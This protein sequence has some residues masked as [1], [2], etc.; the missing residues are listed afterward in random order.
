VYT[1]GALMRGDETWVYYG[2]GDTVIG[3]ATAKTS[4][5]IE[6]CLDN[7]YLGIIGREKGM[8]Q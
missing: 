4:A 1:C 5:L 3:L 7:D 2:A 6:F 8:H